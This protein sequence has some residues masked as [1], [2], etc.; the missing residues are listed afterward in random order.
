MEY[1]IQALQE[2]EVTTGYGI[3]RA[4]KSSASLNQVVSGEKLNEARQTNFVYALAGKAAGIQF[5][6]QSSA[7]LNNNGP[8]VRLRGGSG[9]VASP[10][11]I[12]VVDGT[13][14]V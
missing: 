9:L 3:K 10:K 12:Y 2:V 13:V 5:R 1:D 14:T 7:K 8:Y 6:G 11:V 4:P